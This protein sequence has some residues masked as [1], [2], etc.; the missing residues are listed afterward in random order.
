M[1]MHCEP[2]R[3][4]YRL[5][6]DGG[7]VSD[8][9]LL[10]RFRLHQ[11][12]A[13]FAAL[14]HRHGPMVLAVCR[15]VLRDRHDSEDAFQATF[16][17]LVRK[18]ATVSRPELLGNWL[19]GVALRT[20]KEARTRAARRR[21]REQQA[22]TMPGT[23]PQTEPNDWSHVDEEIQRL[24]A[25]LRQPL[26]LCELEGISRQE[27]ARRLGCPEG[28]LSSRLARARAL[29]RKKLLRRGV[30]LSAGG[31]A[32]ASVPSALATATTR[33]AVL[34][35]AG[36]P[37]VPASILTLTQGVL[38]AMFIAKL[39]ITTA[40]LTVVTALGTG[41][42]LWAQAAFASKPDAKPPV[43][44]QVAESKLTNLVARAD[45][46][47]K[48]AK[49]EQG[50]TFNTTIHSV[51]TTKR[52]ITVLIPEPG[53]KQTKEETFPLAADVKVVLPTIKKTDTPPEGKL[54]DLAEGQN[55]SLQL[56]LDG[57]SVVRIALESPHVHGT[58]KAVDS[59]KRTLTVSHAPPGKKTKELTESTFELAADAPIQLPSL[60][61]DGKKG[62]A[63]LG[64]LSDL[65]EG[66]SVGVRLSWDR[67]QALAV[68]VDVPSINAGVKS[69]NA[70]KGT[71]TITLKSKNGAE[72]QT[73]AVAKDA[74]IH[75]AGPG[76]G[77]DGKLGDILEGGRVVLQLSLD[78]KTVQHID[79]FG[80]PISGSVKALD[81][82]NRVLTVTVKEDGN[83]VDKNYD[84]DK[85]VDLNGVKEGEN[86]SLQL[87][88]DE[89]TVIGISVHKD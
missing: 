46:A 8:G 35:A 54:A 78:R 62:E 10:E 15:R 51:D 53:K 88:A 59:S 19:Y 79:A 1:P 20:A 40:I 21:A 55:A 61:K 34:F 36:S 37:E 45:E 23:H 25:R 52:T 16:L 12:E 44:V 75:L 56:T 3:A 24:P 47:E 83:I 63:N 22:M 9:E 11:E 82:G 72:E 74:K 87:S 66:A 5:M 70:D 85:N 39:K 48:P 57:K 60:K 73:F 65:K 71:I 30:A 81:L 41:A 7:A 32:V 64:T 58:I 28:T 49:K 67:K 84:I 14:V 38:R 17:V 86:V 27:A 29:L 80:A 2:M 77:K 42:G 4:F 31:F 26:I 43:A 76:G 89:K 68:S 6:T 18:A 50:K 69:I 13:A 33:A